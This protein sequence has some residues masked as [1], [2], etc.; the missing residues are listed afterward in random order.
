MDPRIDALAT[1]LASFIG[2]KPQ[3]EV[4]SGDA[5]FRRYFR[6]SHD[7][8][9]YIA[10]DAPVDTEDS[11]LFCAL[12]NAYQQQQINASEVI[13]ADFELGFMWQKDLGDQL[14]FNYLTPESMPHWYR[15]ALNILPKINRICVTE[16][17]SLDSYNHQLL[18]AEL[19]IFNEWLLQRTLAFEFTEQSL[20]AW[21]QLKDILISSA[22]AQPQVG[23]HRDFHS[24]NLM[25][26][27]DELAV[28]DFQG[29]LIGPITYDL[30]S[31]LKD[32]YINC[33]QQVRAKLL[34]DFYQQLDLQGVE[35][36]QFE[37][38]FD[39]MGAQRH[40]KAAGIFC[41]LNL[42]DGK[43]GYLKDVE[44]TL[45]YLVEIADK[46]RLPFI[47]EV[48]ESQVLPSWRDQCGQ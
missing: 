21:Q 27:N 29:A 14:L 39:L 42:R 2:K 31:L 48:L 32:C 41:R 4:V 5:S 38:W 1:W 44:A 43:S 15:K 12:A 47:T 24:R 11:R 3:L 25:V 37:R 8:C 16:L 35:Y 17:G 9:S 22:L 30:V 19:E 45:N 26:N 18:D 6:F 36:S 46:Y 28:I 10:V 34:S 33:P 23:I 20:A 13:K 40:L 7:N